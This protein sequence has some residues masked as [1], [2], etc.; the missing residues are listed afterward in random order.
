M[1]TENQEDEERLSNLFLLIHEDIMMDLRTNKEYSALVDN[2]I[3]QKEKTIEILNGLNKEER[4][5][6]LNYIDSTKEIEM[7]V[8]RALYFQG[9]KDCNQFLDILVY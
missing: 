9:F 8:K 4:K 5:F 2:N 7:I 6:I 1:L 3:K